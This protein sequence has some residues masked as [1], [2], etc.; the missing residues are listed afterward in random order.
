MRR[1]VSFAILLLVMVLCSEAMLCR[2][3]IR[4]NNVTSASIGKDGLIHILL[5]DGAEFVAPRETR[6]VSPAGADDMQV[7]VEAPVIATDRRTVGWLVN[8]P[9]CCT[10]YPIPVTI[11][12]YRGGHIIRRLSNGRAIFRFQFVKGG[13]QVAYFSDTV[14]SNLGPACVLVSVRSGKTLRHWT[15]G[16]GPLPDWAEAFA[17]DVGSVDSSF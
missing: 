7:S 4:A 8:V 3:E 5:S 13:E 17:A 9:N 15:R 2:A 16:D 11:V 6:P 12:L 14:H 1:S 10:S